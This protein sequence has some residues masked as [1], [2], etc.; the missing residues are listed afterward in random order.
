MCRSR[1]RCGSYHLAWKVE[2]VADEHR[3]REL[4]FH[5]I[6]RLTKRIPDQNIFWPGILRK[7][8]EIHKSRISISAIGIIP[9]SFLLFYLRFSPQLIFFAESFGG[10]QRIGRIRLA[11]PAFMTGNRENRKDSPCRCCQDK[12]VYPLYPSWKASSSVRA[13]L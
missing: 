1:N 8:G 11:G 3:H 5:L 2:V 9:H 7:E 13:P 10:R 6:L 4:L 12:N